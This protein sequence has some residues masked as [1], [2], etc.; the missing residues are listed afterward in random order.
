MA[1][2]LFD[3]EGDSTLFTKSVDKSAMMRYNK[4]RGT[5]DP[6]GDAYGRK[7]RDGEDP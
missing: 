6:G 4:S 5:K 1:L 3:G 2:S 7:G